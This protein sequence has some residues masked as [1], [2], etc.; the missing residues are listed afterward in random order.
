MHL[1]EGNIHDSKEAAECNADVNLEGTIFMADKA[2]GSKAIREQ[3]T[4][5]GGT[6]C[7]PP[8]SSEKKPWDCDYHQYSKSPFPVLYRFA[9]TEVNP[10]IAE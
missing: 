7:I 4:S 8:K 3:I 9:M 2:Y 1:S 5:G 10:Y 6:V